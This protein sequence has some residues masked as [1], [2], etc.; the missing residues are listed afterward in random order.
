MKKMSY[1]VIKQIKIKDNKV[2]IT[3]ASNNVYPR[4]PHESECISLSEVLQKEG[5]EKVDIEILEEYESGNFQ[6]G[7]NKYT[8]ALE[9]LRHIPE[10]RS[11]DWRTNEKE[12]KD[13]HENRQTRK[14][15]FRELM[16]SAL[17]TRLPKDKYVITK[18][19]D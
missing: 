15:E 16:R 18:L 1:E 11:F 10:Y 12:Y 9:V 7:K 4:T 5:R 14:D 8:R 13:N 19:A 6:G 2:F 17:N 3:G